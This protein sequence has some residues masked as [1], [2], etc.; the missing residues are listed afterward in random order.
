[1]FPLHNSIP[2]MD[3]T[4]QRCRKIRAQERDN[5][6]KADTAVEVAVQ[7]LKV[8]DE[9]IEEVTKGY[10]K[11]VENDD[12]VLVAEPKD[13]IGIESI[14]SEPHEVMTEEVCEKL[15]SAPTPHCIF[16]ETRRWVKI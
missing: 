15:S 16:S 1:M 8:Y 4:R 2:G 11:V 12:K 3:Q 14:T 5:A 13:E 10:S 6:Q 9:V 7:Q